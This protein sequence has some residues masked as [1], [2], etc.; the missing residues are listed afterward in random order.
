MFEIIFSYIIF[1]GKKQ[2][3][4]LSSLYNLKVLGSNLF[5]E[6]FSSLNKMDENKLFLGNFLKLVI[7]EQF[8]QRESCSRKKKKKKRT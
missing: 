4:W 8:L 3:Q 7:Q 6:F 2:M 1:K 5:F